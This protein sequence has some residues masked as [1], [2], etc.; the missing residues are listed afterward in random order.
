MAPKSSVQDILNRLLRAA[1]EQDH[2]RLL[3][4]T[5][6]ETSEM[7]DPEIFSYADNVQDILKLLNDLV[8]PPGQNNHLYK[9]EIIINGNNFE[10]VDRYVKNGMVAIRIPGITRMRYFDTMTM[11]WLIGKYSIDFMSI[12]GSTDRF[13]IIL[14]MDAPTLVIN[15]K[16]L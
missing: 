15:S 6:G 10:V 1:E 16:P 7:D 13:I 14:S 4:D 12:P 11:K 9:V 3:R 8:D 2:R 5:S